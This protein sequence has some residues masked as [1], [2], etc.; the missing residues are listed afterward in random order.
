M[1]I[2]LSTYVGVFSFFLSI[3]DNRYTLCITKRKSNKINLKK[4]K[5]NETKGKN[6]VN[7][8]ELVYYVSNYQPMFEFSF[9][10]YYFQIKSIINNM[11]VGSSGNRMI[12]TS[13]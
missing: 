10:F 9:S 1:P 13:F 8:I 3:S 5:K 12:V 7:K 11:I 4:K 6:E 2:K